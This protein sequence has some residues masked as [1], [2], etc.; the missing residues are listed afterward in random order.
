MK[1]LW[2]NADATAMV[3]LYAKQGVSEDV[4]LRTYSA[5]LL[6]SDRSLVLHG[7]GNT[8]V[9]TGMRDVYGDL[10]NVLCVKGSGWD[11]STIEPAGHPAVRLEPLFRLRKLKTLSDEEMVNVQR[12]NMLDSSGPN[13]SVETLLHAYIPHKFV[14]HTHSTTALAIADQPDAIA[15]GQ[16]IW[17]KRV[18]YV[19]YSMPGFA[20]AKAAADAFDAD[21]TVEGLLLVKH[22]LFSFGATAKESYERMIRLVSEAE[23]YIA[24]NARKRL[25][26]MPAVRKAASQADA[27]PVLRGLFCAAAKAEGAHGHWI[28]DRRATD[29]VM[30]VVNAKSVAE[31]TRRGVATPDHVIRTRTFPLVLDAPKTGEIDTWAKESVARLNAYIADYKA[32]FARQNK[33]VKGIKKT[34]DPLPR[35]II[36]P[37][38]GAFGLGKTAAE[39]AIIGD[40]LEAWAETVIDAESIGRY[41]P[42]GEDDSFDMEYWSL[43]QAKLGKASLKRF[44]GQIVAIT[45]AGSGLGAATAKAFADEGA[46]VAILDLDLKA[47]LGVATSL[48]KNA[49]AVA[50]DVTK[51]DSVA[52]AF[53]AVVERFGGLDIVVSNAGAGFEGAI[54]TVDESIL[55]KSFELNFFGH[56]RVAQNAVRIMKAQKLGGAL[57]FN[58]SKIAINPGK[59]FGPYGLAKVALLGLVRQYALEHGVDGI[60]ANAVNPARIR[61]N[62]LTPEMIAARA[63]ARGISVAEYLGGNLLGREVTAEDVAQAFIHHA[64]MRNTTGDVTTVDGGDVSAMLR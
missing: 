59:D 63:R 36:I 6:G 44:A 18:G 39:A 4:A 31:L 7:G 24:A 15:L 50:C 61:S 48:G 27:L 12:Q 17:G 62:L 41:E 64:L 53:A 37:G 2:K 40:I 22:G 46:E 45:G 26:Q 55:R 42:I 29:R 38:M 30:S 49:L 8:S 16:R 47:A 21:P 60:R 23:T 35:V 9:K 1:S 34:L 51:P 20:L 33:R 57:L 13:P 54:A 28:M 32:M 14:D 11:I 58:V 43:E 25:A 5:R 10:V 3:A 19:P 56:Q 52:S